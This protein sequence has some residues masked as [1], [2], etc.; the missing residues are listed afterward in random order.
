MLK[1]MS[2]LCHIIRPRSVH[3]TCRFESFRI[4]ALQECTLQIA[5]RPTL[6]LLSIIILCIIEIS[7]YTIQG[8]KK[9]RRKE[10][11]QKFPYRGC[12]VHRRRKLRAYY[13]ATV[14]GNNG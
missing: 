7:R 11:E 9:N 6:S 5:Y 8:G 10:I 4:K 12:I 14:M 3:K 2:S 13:E 1:L